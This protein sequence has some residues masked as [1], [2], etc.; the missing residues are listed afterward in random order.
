MRTVLWILLTLVVVGG[1]TAIGAST[2]N[3]SA[4]GA[5]PTASAP[6][7]ATPG[8]AE[9]H[10]LLPEEAKTRIDSGDPVVIVDVRTAAEFAESRIPGAI[11]VPNEEIL[12]QMPEALPDK[13]AELLI[14]CRSGRRSSDAAHKLVAMGYTRVYDFGGIIDWPYETEQ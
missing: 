14:Y 4:N 9:Y 10:K 13:D 12:D 5:A 6:A 2:R 7:T 3:A 1:L 8:P 11:N